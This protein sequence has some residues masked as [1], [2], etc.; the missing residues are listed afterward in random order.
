M[1]VS[2][3][4]IAFIA[5]EYSTPVSL[6]EV[7]DITREVDEC[8]KERSKPYQSDGLITKRRKANYSCISHDS[9]IMFSTLLKF[10]YASKAFVHLNK[11][12]W[13]V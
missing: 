1:I 7:R 6:G 10:S 4:L 11:I 9:S 8:L 2:F 13:R 12:L 3:H 5:D